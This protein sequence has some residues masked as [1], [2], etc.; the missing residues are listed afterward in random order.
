M[1]DDAALALLMRE[2]SSGRV[3]SRRKCSLSSSIGLERSNASAD[4]VLGI[5][6]I[7]APNF[8]T[9]HPSGRAL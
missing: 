2:M 9:P 6:N 8:L 3:G 1:R 5:E 7:A 4:I